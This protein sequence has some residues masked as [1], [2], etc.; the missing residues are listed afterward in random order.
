M[1]KNEE[2]TK[3]SLYVDMSNYRWLWREKRIRERSIAWIVNQAIAQYRAR[4]EKGRSKRTEAS[5]SGGN[6]HGDG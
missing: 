2:K 1:V 6:D 5:S 4:I 3:M